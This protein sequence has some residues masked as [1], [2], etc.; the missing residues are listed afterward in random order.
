MDYLEL[1]ELDEITPAQYANAEET[2]SKNIE[3][4]GQRESFQPEQYTPKEIEDPFTAL[5]FGNRRAEEHKRQLPADQPL[6]HPYGFYSNIDLDAMFGHID[7]LIESF[8]GLKP[9][10]QKVYP[11]IEQYIKKK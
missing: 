2:E 7:T 10:F 1:N 5:M 9:L 8:R 11:V 4:R 3:S 6:Y